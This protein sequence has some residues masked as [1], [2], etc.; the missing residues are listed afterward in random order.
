MQFPVPNIVQGLWIRALVAACVTLAPG[1]VPAQ[2]SWPERPLQLVVPFPAGGAVDIAARAFAERFGE[3]IGRP[4]VIVNREGASGTIGVAQVANARADG[5]TLGFVT[6][7]PL[8]IQPHLM[9]DLPYK[10]DDLVPVCQVF[11]S[12]YVLATAP[13]SKIASLGD[14]IAASK[15]GK[16]S[17]GFGGVGTT[18]HLLMSQFVNAAGLDLL[19][20]PFRADPPA[21]VGLRAGEVDVAPLNLGLAR[22]QGLRVLATFAQERQAAFPNAPTLTESGWAITGSVYGG[23]IA[24]KGVAEDVVRRF[25]AACDKAVADERFRTVM[26]TASQEPVYRGPAAF[27]RLLAQDLDTSREMV[28]AAKIA[29]N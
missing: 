17:Y 3:G 27:A 12:Q 15:A 29:P 2:A 1:V 13:T 23:L 10:R 16:L 6:H 22:A 19:A 5:Y 14:L 25:D 21:I 18:P 28:R 4:V 8:V 7:G 11:A 26:K 24:P 9:K 20:V